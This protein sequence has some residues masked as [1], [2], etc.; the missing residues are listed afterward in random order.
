MDGFHPVSYSFAA[1]P[2]PYIK[3]Y[4]LLQ[5]KFIHRDK[6]IQIL[7][8]VEIFFH[9]HLLAARREQSLT[10]PLGLRLGKANFLNLGVCRSCSPEVVT[11]DQEM[12]VAAICEANRL[13]REKNVDQVLHKLRRPR[14]SAESRLTHGKP[15][16]IGSQKTRRRHGSTGPPHVMNTVEHEKS[17]ENIILVSG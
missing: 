1:G 4:K 10:L 6:Y 16:S 15:K 2:R 5:M 17:G 12:P 14:K 8:G 11:A 7:G 3:Y 9:L 13:L